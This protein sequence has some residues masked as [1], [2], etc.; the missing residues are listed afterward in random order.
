MAALFPPPD[1]PRSR[2]RVALGVLRLGIHANRLV[3]FEPPLYGQVKLVPVEPLTA[4]IEHQGEVK[5][6][7]VV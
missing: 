5:S 7:V 6:P 4:L 2:P 1:K 3:H